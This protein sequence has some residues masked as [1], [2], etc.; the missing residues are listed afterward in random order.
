MVPLNIFRGVSSFSYAFSA[1]VNLAVTL[2]SQS[3]ITGTTHNYREYSDTEIRFVVSRYIFEKICN[4]E[5]GWNSPRNMQM[6]PFFQIFLFR[7]CVSEFLRNCAL[8]IVAEQRSES[9][10]LG[11]LR[12]KTLSRWKKISQPAMLPLLHLLNSIVS[13]DGIFFFNY[14]RTIK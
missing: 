6:Q 10:F 11:G 13:S 1:I 7:A 12:L 5:S 14:S 2:A 8:H 3:Q 4:H 9:N